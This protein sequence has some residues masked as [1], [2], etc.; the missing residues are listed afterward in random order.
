MHLNNTITDLID[1]HEAARVLGVSRG[2]LDNWRRKGKLQ[3]IRLGGYVIR[4]K[5]AGHSSLHRFKP[6]RQELS[7]VAG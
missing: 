4:F 1:K 3:Y 2:T 5:R 7:A 6:I